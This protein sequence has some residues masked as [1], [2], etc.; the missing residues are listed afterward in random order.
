MVTSLKIENLRGIKEGEI[1]HLAPLSIIV[2][3]NGSGK[4][5]LLEAL[6]FG[7]SAQPSGPFRAAVA[8]RSGSRSP[9]TWLLWRGGLNGGS[10]SVTVG[11]ESGPSRR[12]TLSLQNAGEE[13]I[14]G[15]IEVATSGSSWDVVG[16]L[17]FSRNGA[18]CSGG[19]VD[20]NA[21][22]A[23]VCLLDEADR[24]SHIPLDE[25]YSR[26]VKAGHRRD[27]LEAVKALLPAVHAVEIL[28][29]QGE[30]E[31]H[32]VFEE[33][34][35][36]AGMA[37]DGIA[38]VLR[39]ALELVRPPG[40][41]VLLEE[42]EMHKHPAAMVQSA[43]SLFGAVRRG[44]QVVLTTHS[45]ELIDAILNEAKTDEELKHVAL[46]RV[47]LTDGVLS[48]YREAGALAAEARAAIAEDLR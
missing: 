4:S 14:T 18:G 6:L 28:T 34:S 48:V 8:R 26:A 1:A 19:R 3:P 45:L 27:A 40:G 32:L 12:T 9:W 30:P 39:E 42:P 29:E 47:K 46:F 33:F 7:A 21:S 23:D 44:V 31:V 35:I 17:S 24:E 2:G 43:K 41:L 22:A 10:T 16:G 38:A 13:A 15:Q 5:T 20:S 37:G 11:F 36:P 25:A